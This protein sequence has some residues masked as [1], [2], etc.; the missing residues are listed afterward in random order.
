MITCIYKEL[1]ICTSRFALRLA[2]LP[3]GGQAT[4]LIGA[5]DSMLGQR[6]QSFLG[7]WNGREETDLFEVATS[8]QATTT[9]EEEAAAMREAQ[10]RADR[11]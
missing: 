6:L 11:D 7:C 9:I 4:E 8:L 5:P 3:G 10:F 1:T 2:S